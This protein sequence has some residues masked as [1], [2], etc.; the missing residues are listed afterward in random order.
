MDIWD[1]VNPRIQKNDP[2]WGES[3]LMN[4]QL[5]LTLNA[6]SVMVDKFVVI[7]CGYASTGHEEK[8]EHYRG[9]AVDFSFLDI[10]FAEAIRRIEVAIMMLQISKF[11]G[12][13]LY[14]QWKK[15][16]FHLDIRPNAGR[17]AKL[18]EKYIGYEAGRKYAID[19]NL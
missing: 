12:L 5:I 9:C 4:G 6:I 17:W 18:D 16:G 1:L 15:P 11:I 13:G 7:N 19:K 14:P 3:S 10:K 8:S 2:A